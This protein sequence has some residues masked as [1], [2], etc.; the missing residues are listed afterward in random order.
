MCVKL[1]VY[2]ISQTL[3]K[4]N[5]ILFILFC[6]M[7]LISCKKKAKQVVDDPIDYKTINFNIYPNDP[8]Y[9]K[10]KY[11]G[12]WMY[13]NDQGINGIII[14]RQTETNTTADFIA[15]ERT[16]TYYPNNAKAKVNVLTDNFTLKDTVS[17]S[18]WQI[19]NGAVLNGPATIA[20]RFYSTYY[21]SSTGTLN[22]KN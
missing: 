7:C 3:I 22:I 5:C 4:K 9:N 8:L 1:F 14:Y 19:T 12:G 18:T 16:S 15:I 13:I 20:L 2:T 21:N 11:A 6:V 17:G 10:I